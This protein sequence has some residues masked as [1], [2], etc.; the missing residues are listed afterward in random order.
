LLQQRLQQS[1]AS[2]TGAEETDVAELHL[3]ASI[4]YEEQGLE[5]EAF[6]HAAA[7]N[8]VE[9]AERL[10]GG[11][12]IPLHMRGAAMAILDWLRSLPTAVMDARP[13]LWVRHA[14]LLLVNGQTTGVE[15]KLQAAENALRGAELNDQIRDLVGRIAAARAT[16]ALT[17]YQVEPM[18]AQ[19]HR[20]LEYLPPANLSLRANAYWTLGFAYF[21]QGDRAGARQA[22]TEGISLG[23]TAGALYTTLL[24]T[25]G[26]GQVQ[27]AENQLH[28]AAETYRRVP[29]LAGDQPFQ[30]ICEAHLGRARVLFEWNELDT[31]SQHGRQGLHLARQYESVVDRFIICEVFLARLRLAEGDTDGASALLA[32]AGQSALQNNFVYRIP[33]VAAV[34]VL[35]LL[36]QGSVAAAARLAETHDL[37]LSRARVHLA[38]GD[39]GKA[40][41]VLEPW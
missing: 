1:I 33:E 37:A 18:I 5:L 10:M 31:A 2:S 29:Q 12:G 30:A 21:L 19:S 20:A 34:Q 11:K 26:L 9:R 17:R 6:Q 32:E 7:A 25:I 40:L 23:Q 35:T 15:E 13:S 8:D 27:E 28:Q 4:W 24:A 36:Q 41:A 22:Y 3:R 14:S 38:Q 16:L 39:P